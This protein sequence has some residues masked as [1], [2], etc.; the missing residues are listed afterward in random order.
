MVAITGAKYVDM[1]DIDDICS[2]RGA[3]PR[4]SSERGVLSEQS[5]ESRLRKRTCDGTTCAAEG[6]AGASDDRLPAE[7]PKK[8]ARRTARRTKNKAVAAAS[9]PDQ[10]FNTSE[11]RVLQLEMELL[12]HKNGALTAELALLRAGVGGTTSSTGAQQL[13]QVHGTPAAAGNPSSTA[14]R[15]WATSPGWPM[16]LMP[17]SQPSGSQQYTGMEPAWTAPRPVAPTQTAT[18]G[19]P[20]AHPLPPSDGAAQ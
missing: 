6:G 2:G 15:P 13:S 19:L 8:L 7:A 5:R 20:P 17:A 3:G 12:E 18:P 1:K 16:Q 11:R 4:T 10:A 9:A 14:G